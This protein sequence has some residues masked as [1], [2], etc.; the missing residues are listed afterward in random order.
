MEVASHSSNMLNLSK[1]DHVKVG[2]AEKKY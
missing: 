1:F 2:T